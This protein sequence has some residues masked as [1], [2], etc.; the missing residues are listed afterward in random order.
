MKQRNQ[1]ILSL[2]FVACLSY[3]GSAFAQDAT[4]TA[5]N[6]AV[7]TSDPA[8]TPAYF[9]GYYPSGCTP[10]NTAAGVV[11]TC[12]CIQDPKTHDIWLA[13]PAKVNSVWS[14]ANNWATELNSGEGTC[15][16]TSGW[17]LATQ[18]QIST[19]VRYT[20]DLPSEDQKVLWMDNNGFTTHQS[21]T[22]GGSSFWGSDAG[23]PVG[24]AWFWN[25]R[26]AGVWQ[27]QLDMPFCKG[28]AV[29][30]G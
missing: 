30:S 10:N 27:E 17:G 6:D 15:G 1:W 26:Y 7:V 8:V 22:S 16:F 21:A 19:M 25:V 5:I 9:I 12:T 20:I 14:T 23:A 29:H 28:L 2:G 3:S 11:G 24:L 18:E 13:A 4:D